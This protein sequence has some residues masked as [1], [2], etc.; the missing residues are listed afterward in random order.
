VRACPI[1]LGQPVIQ[2]RLQFLQTGVK[3]LAKGRGV[4]LFLNG[5]L[6]AFADAV[7]LGMP[8]FGAAVIDVLHRQV[9]LVFAVF[10]LTAVLGAAIGEHTQK[11]DLVLFEKGQHAVVEQIGRD[12]GV[13]TVIEFGESHLGVGVEEVC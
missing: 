9:Q 8:G 10:A 7:G 13:L 1:V 12:Q 5:A 3:L 11:R 4:E 6:E 2:I